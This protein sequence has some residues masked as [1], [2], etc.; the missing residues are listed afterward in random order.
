MGENG[1]QSEEEGIYCGQQTTSRLT[2]QSQGLFCFPY[3]YDNLHSGLLS[4]KN[5]ITVRKGIAL[6]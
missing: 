1:T 4:G 3:F 5:C 6:V 2:D